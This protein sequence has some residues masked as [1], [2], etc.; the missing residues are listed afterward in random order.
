ME[1]S[2]SDIT[3]DIVTEFTWADWQKP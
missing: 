1:K 2:S 3:S